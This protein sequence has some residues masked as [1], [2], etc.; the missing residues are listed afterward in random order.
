MKKVNLSLKSY[1]VAVMIETERNSETE[2]PDILPLE[3]I[4]KVG[5]S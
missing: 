3:E 4:F 2:L 1:S 5:F